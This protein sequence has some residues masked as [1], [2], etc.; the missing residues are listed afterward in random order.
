[1]KCKD[2]SNE[3]ES[4]YRQYLN[5]IYSN[6]SN[7]TVKSRVDLNLINNRRHTQDREHFFTTLIQNNTHNT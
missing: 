4:L 3:L 2:T 1:M 7:Y 5:F 6:L